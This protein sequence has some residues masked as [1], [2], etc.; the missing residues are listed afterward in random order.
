MRISE[1]ITESKVLMDYH[2]SLKRSTGPVVLI[3][4]DHQG[5]WANN[6][7][8]AKAIQ[9]TIEY[10]KKK[11]L[12]VSC[13]YEGT[14]VTGSKSFQSFWKHIQKK[15]PNTEFVKQT[16]EPT[17]NYTKE[18]ELCMDLFGGD[19]PAF[20]KQLGLKGVFIDLLLKQPY[21]WTSIDR[22]TESDIKKLVS[23][24][25]HKDEYLH[26]LEQEISMSVLKKW[27]ELCQEAFEDPSSRLYKINDAPQEKRRKGISTLMKSTPG[28]YLIGESH[29]PVMRKAN[30]LP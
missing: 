27:F 16:W 6:K 22:V 7:N 12:P 26:L 19:A 2:I 14:S 1:V 24:G 8:T 17:V 18:E 10:F 20:K 13:W 21:S 23:K 25:N 3:G 29:I 9:E 15:N 4:E 11:Q 28:I 30:Q 5:S